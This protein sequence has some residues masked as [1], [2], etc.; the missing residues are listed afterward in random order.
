MG[1]SAGRANASAEG[2]R[3]FWGCLRQESVSWRAVAL[4]GRVA[5]LAAR[6]GGRFLRYAVVDFDIILTVRTGTLLAS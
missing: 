5:I 6:A 1:K 3:V 2:R 4:T